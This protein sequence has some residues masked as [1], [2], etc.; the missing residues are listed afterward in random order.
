[1]L[2]LKRVYKALNF[3]K[4]FFYG[5]SGYGMAG[6]ALKA[7]IDSDH[8]FMLI[9]AGNMIGIPVI[10]SYY[11]LRLLPYSVPGI[12]AWKRRMLRERDMIDFL[13]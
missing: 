6:F 8:L 7:R 1:M 12:S 2:S 11:S 10:P 5:L 4:G 9:N 13:I 3:L